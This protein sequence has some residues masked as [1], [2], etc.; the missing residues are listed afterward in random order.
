M[1]QLLSVEG[2]PLGLGH[3]AE[4]GEQED[5][6]VW[7]P[8]CGPWLGLLQPNQQ[9]EGFSYWHVFKGLSVV[10][11]SRQLLAGHSDCVDD[12]ILL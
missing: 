8:I 9:V 5:L 4:Q 2:G 10:A 11:V 12:Q 3:R 1:F 7:V 6:Q